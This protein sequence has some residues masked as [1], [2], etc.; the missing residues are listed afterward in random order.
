MFSFEVQSC[1]R[2]YHIYKAVWTPYIGETL[3]C[4]RELTNGH[5]PFSVNFRGEKFRER[6][7]NHENI[8]PRKFGAIRYFTDSGL[9]VR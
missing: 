1:I 7:V 4:F 8:V 2:G 3:P 9:M 5:D 6:G